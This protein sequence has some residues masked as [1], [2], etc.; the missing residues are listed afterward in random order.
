MKRQ[1]S[2]RA[3]V[4][5]TAAV[6]VTPSPF[7]GLAAEPPATPS[8]AAMK[9]KVAVQCECPGCERPIAQN[10]IRRRG[11]AERDRREPHLVGVEA[12]CEGCDVLYAVT[13]ANTGGGRLEPVGEVEVVEDPARR[14]EFFLATADGRRELQLSML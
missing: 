1:A 5:A 12:Y 2:A 10:Y 7:A 4:A 8:P 3:V 6:V 9:I 11:L 14:N 13:C